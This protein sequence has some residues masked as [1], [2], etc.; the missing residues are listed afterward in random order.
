L[1]NRR[2]RNP[3]ITNPLSCRIFKIIAGMDRF[4]AKTHKRLIP[5]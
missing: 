1:Q 3:K 2:S 4:Y 5:L